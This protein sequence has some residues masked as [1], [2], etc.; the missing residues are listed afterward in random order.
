MSICSQ[1]TRAETDR[2]G[3]DLVEMA[4][5]DALKARIGVARMILE[6]CQDTTER[7]G[8]SETQADVVVDLAKRVSNL[9]VEDIASLVVLVNRAQWRRYDALRIHAALKSKKRI[10]HSIM[11]D[12]VRFPWYVPKRIQAF[13]VSIGVDP[14]LKQEVL[15]DF[16][17]LL[18]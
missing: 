11:Q 4:D 14:T 15:L 8:V 13:L 16:L 2:K 18:G 5:V 6:E 3:C 10:A 7:D 9:S 1:T 17:R 12:W